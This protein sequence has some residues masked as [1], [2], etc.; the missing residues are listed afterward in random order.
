M[1]NFHR[2][3]SESCLEKNSDGKID[4]IFGYE[5]LCKSHGDELFIF[6]IKINGYFIYEVTFIVI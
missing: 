2:L 3:Q 5:N 4:N 1:N 6:W